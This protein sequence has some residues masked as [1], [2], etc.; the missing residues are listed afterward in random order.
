MSDV[1]RV[2]SGPAF[3][4]PYRALDGAPYHGDSDGTYAALVLDS[5]ACDAL[6]QRWIVHHDDMLDAV[7][8]LGV[9][10]ED[11]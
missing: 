8:M 7:M 1:R 6:G 10:W 9:D 3:T 4:A 2:P 11:G 5:V